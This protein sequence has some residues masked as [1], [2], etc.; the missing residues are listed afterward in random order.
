MKTEAFICLGSSEMVR[1]ACSPG[2]FS[3]EAETRQGL[4]R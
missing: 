1:S 3:P 2:N 4:R